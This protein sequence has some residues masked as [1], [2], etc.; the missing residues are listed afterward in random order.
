MFT[1]RCQTFFEKRLGNSKC[2]LTTSCTD[3]LE[4]CALLANVGPGDEVIVPS[5]TFVSSALAFARQGARI[6]FAD[7]RSDNPC[8]DERLLEPLITPRTKAIVAVH[9]A[10]IACDMDSLVELCRRHH[11][12]LI[13]DAAQAVNSFYKGRPLGSMGQLA[14]FSFHETKN[15]QC[16]EGGL[17]AINEPGLVSRAE[18]MWEKGTNRASF[19]RGEVNKYGWVE[20]GS[21][22]LPSEYT[23]AF[24]WAQLQ[25]WDAI[26]EKR[27]TLWTCYQKELQ[28][29]SRFTLPQ[30]PSYA[31]HN[32]HCFYGVCSTGEERNRLMEYLKEHGIQAT[33]HYIALHQSEYVK[34]QGWPSQ[35]LPQACR[36]TDCLLRLPLYNALTVNEVHEICDCVKSFYL[37]QRHDTA[38]SK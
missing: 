17:L 7:S 21:S 5:Y 10:G 23:A 9:Y 38:L 34:K 30:I 18:M 16:G 36:Y 2:L 29:L 4:M 31:Q 14:T 32:A 37:P 27:D 26:Q 19:F 11:L 1:R 28:G 13:E 3:A 6:V 33:F 35:E 15:I 22:F 24:L 8:M 20:T 12:F 25:E